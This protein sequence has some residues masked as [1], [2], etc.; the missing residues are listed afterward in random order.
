MARRKLEVAGMPAGVEIEVAGK[1]YNAGQGLFKYIYYVRIQCGIGN[2]N[3]RAQLKCAELAGL[4]NEAAEIKFCSMVVG[5]RGYNTAIRNL[6]PNTNRAA[7]SEPA[8]SITQQREWEY[9]LSLDA[10]YRRPVAL[11]SS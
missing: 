1:P 8:G 7:E 2:G 9:V 6:R 4:S 11:R 3:E 5:S 10:R